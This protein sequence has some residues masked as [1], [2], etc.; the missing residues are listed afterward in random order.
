MAG[1]EEAIRVISLNP[2]A[3]SFWISCSEPSRSL[4]VFTR[5]EAIMWGRWLTAPTL[6]SWVRG[7]RIRGRAPVDDIRFLNQFKGKTSDITFGGDID[8]L[9]GAT[10]SS[11][12]V[13]VGVKA[14]LDELAGVS[15]P[16]EIDE[17]ASATKE[18]D[19]EASATPET[20]GEASAT[21]ETDAEASAT[22]NSAETDDQAS[23]TPETDSEASATNDAEGGGE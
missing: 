17:E 21:A 19:G 7:S 22:E 18:T 4:T 9:A 12:A 8:A 10:V 15:E 13:Y 5:A 3:A 14:A 11:R 20:D 23:A 1:L 6:W 2:P 16:A